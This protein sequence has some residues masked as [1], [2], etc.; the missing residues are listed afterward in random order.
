VHRF[1]LTGFA[2]PRARFV[3]DCSKG[4]YV[5]SLVRDLGAA[6]GCGATLTALRRTRSGRFTLAEA[7]PLDRVTPAE[8]AARL[9]PPEDAVAHLPAM[10]LAGEDLMR[11][12]HGKPLAAPP[13]LA[14]G[15]VV[16]ALTPAG[17]L[18]ALVR[19]E[20]GGRLS[21]VRVFNYGFVT[22]PS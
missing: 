3:V 6:L 4:T 12:R 17:A 8:A 5:R 13:D 11:V 20:P 7:V 14:P 2:P 18:A 10:P 16:R 22:G 9:V 21:Y 15:E 1:E 19:V